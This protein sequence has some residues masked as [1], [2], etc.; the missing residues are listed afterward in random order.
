MG[1]RV[2]DS[3]GSSGGLVGCVSE[4]ERGIKLLNARISFSHFA[5]VWGVYGNREV[6][7]RKWNYGWVNKGYQTAIGKGRKRIN[8]TC[9][10]LILGALWESLFLHA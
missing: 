5:L 1:G 8:G 2:G 3:G 10:Y 6:M 4:G 7:I 9:I